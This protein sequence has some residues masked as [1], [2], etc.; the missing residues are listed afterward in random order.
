MPNTVVSAAR[1]RE[2]QQVLA[3]LLEDRRREILE[4][5]RSLREAPADQAAGADAEE[6]SVSDL[7]RD[8]DCALMEMTSESLRRIDEALRRLADGRYGE[9]AECGREISEARLKAL[10]FALLCLPCQ[11]REE[12][13]EEAGRD[14]PG[15]PSRLDA[16]GPRLPSPFAEE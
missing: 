5:L 1:R 11:E 4:K 15:P 10:P 13:R 16:V 14:R 8:L 7:V 3:A 6:L 2:R 12:E 9:C